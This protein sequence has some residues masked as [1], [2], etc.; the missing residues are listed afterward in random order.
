MAVD[1]LEKLSVVVCTHNPR[2]D[3]LAETLAALRAQTLSTD[4]WELAVIDNASD[5]PLA[6]RFDIGWHPR[7]RLIVE[8]QLGLTPARLRGIQETTGELIVFVDDDNVLAPDYLDQAMEIAAE[9]PFIG[10]FSG[11]A[12]PR[13]ESPP[14]EWTKAYWKYLAL[15][16]VDRDQWSNLCPVSPTSPNGAGM[17]VRRSVAEAYAA[18]VADDPLRR[19]LDRRGN[20]LMSSG[21]TDLAVR[22]CRCGLGAGVFAALT[23]T[24]LIPAARLTEDYLARIIEGT[25]YSTILVHAVNGSPPAP[26]EHRP[27]RAALGRAKRRLLWGRRQRRLFEAELR[28]IHK[29]VEVWTRYASRSTDVATSSS[30]GACTR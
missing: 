11:N 17:C 7:G 10:A 26:I 21:D 1:G 5:P 13:F 16:T 14:A 29:G 3:F 30:S 20:S 6:G 23:L 12:E 24:H 18:S 15:R 9:H 8:D 4:Q 22:A 25:I 27:W 28:G 2:R 19:E